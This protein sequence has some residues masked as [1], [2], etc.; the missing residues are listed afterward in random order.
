MERALCTWPKHLARR[1][2]PGRPRCV[3]R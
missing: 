1:A 2:I 3:H